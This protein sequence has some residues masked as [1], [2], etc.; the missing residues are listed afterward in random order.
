[1]IHC[2]RVVLIVLLLSGGL[3]IRSAELQAETPKTSHAGR[4]NVLFVTSDDLGLQLGCYGDKFAHTPN[5]DRLAGQGVRFTRGFVTQSS[6]SPSRSSLLTGLYPHQNGQIGLSHRGY[7]MHRRDLPT[8]P[9]LL[10]KVG[11]TTGIIGKLHVAPE[12]AFPFDYK[13]TNYPDARDIRK[14]RQRAAEFLTQAEG[15][16]FFL[17]VNFTDPHDPML[18]DVGGHPLVKAEA[19]DI[20]PLLFMVKDDPKIRQRVADYYTCVN[21]V[22]EGMGLLL[23]LLE[24]KQVADNTLIV[25]IGDNGPPLPPAKTTCYEAG[26]QVPYL[27][28]WPHVVPAGQVCDAL[29][30]TVDLMPTFLEAAGVATPVGLPGS[31]L[32][33][34]MTGQDPKWRRYLAAEYTVHTPIMYFPQ[35][36]IRDD[37][38]KLIV[39]L[40]HDPAILKQLRDHGIDP[41]KEFPRFATT[42]AVELYDLAKDPYERKNLAADPVCHEVL[43]R[44]QKE[45]RAWQEAT[46]DPLLD[47]DYFVKLTRSHLGAGEKYLGLGK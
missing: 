13:Q 32:L 16:P 22:D 38:Y 44:L 28:R 41:A 8:L 46:K 21:R 9:G 6:C 34:L 11:Y 33:G 35:R 43:S 39:S 14:V 30:S 7:S 19:K 20:E 5:L 31:S 36:T 12:E 1:M 45:L 18:R 37:R 15:R 47:S 40:L 27:V 23:R 10:K 26:L 4:P 25:V 29:V 3:G 42:P 2:R 17:M 24:E